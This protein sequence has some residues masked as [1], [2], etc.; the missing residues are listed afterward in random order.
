MG[1]KDLFLE[2]EEIHTKMFD[3]LDE[4]WGATRKFQLSAKQEQIIKDWHAMIK[5]GLNL[6]GY[7]IEDIE[8]IV[9]EQEEE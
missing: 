2:I 4:V 8:E 1:N 5:D 6:M 9:E 3:M 7:T